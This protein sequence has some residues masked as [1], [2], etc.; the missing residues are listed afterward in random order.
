MKDIDF[1]DKVS[2]FYPR[3]NEGVTINADRDW[4]VVIMSF[5]V[6]LII[7]I[8]ISLYDVWQLKNEPIIEAPSTESFSFERELFNKAIKGIDEKKMRFDKLF[9]EK[10]EIKD[11]SL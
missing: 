4:M 7:V 2:Y 8:L 3:D 11:P 10:P 6:I 5:W 1:K 9:I